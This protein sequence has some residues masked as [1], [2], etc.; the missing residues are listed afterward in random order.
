MATIDINSNNYET[1]Q[2]PNSPKLFSLK[3]PKNYDFST[4]KTNW[5][6]YKPF[7]ILRSDAVWE[8]S[9]LYSY[10][11]SEFKSNYFYNKGNYHLISDTFFY[12]TIQN[13]IHN[14][15]DKSEIG[16]SKEHHPKAA[17]LTKNGEI[18]TM[19][20]VVPK[21]EVR[22]T[23]TFLGDSAKDMTVLCMLKFFKW[24]S[25]NDKSEYKIQM[26]NKNYAPELALKYDCYREIHEMHEHCIRY[27]FKVMFEM[28]Y[29]RVNLDYYHFPN[30]ISVQK[31][32]TNTTRPSKARVLYY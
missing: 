8:K 4:R 9:K 12:F 23:S 3:M 27:H 20:K 28:Y 13:D 5:S 6:L 7:Y 30:N 14:E 22:R 32:G 21:Q 26:V 15:F 24:M 17:P 29:L 1:N 16:E 31:V 2:N 11:Y 10:W 25:C 18:F 19:D